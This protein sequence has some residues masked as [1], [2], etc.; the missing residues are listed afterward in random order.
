MNR[1]INGW[2]VTK[3]TYMYGLFSSKSSCNPDIEN[4][5]VSNVLDFVSSA[6]TFLF[7][8]LLFSSCVYLMYSILSMFFF[9]RQSN[10]RATCL[11][12]QGPSMETFPVGTH[13]RHLAW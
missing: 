11:I 10:H 2:N 6:I 7:R 1:P 5:D 12:M 8:L 9:E 13:L 3:I 4:W